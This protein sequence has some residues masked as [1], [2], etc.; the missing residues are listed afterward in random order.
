MV[1][2]ALSEISSHLVRKALLETIEE[3]LHSKNFK[4]K[5]TSASKAGE[6]NFIGIIHRVIFTK[7]DEDGNEN[8]PAANLILKVAPQNLLRRSQ[9]VVRPAFERE[10]YS[11]EKVSMCH[12]LIK[13][14]KKFLMK[15]H[16]VFL[17][18]LPAFRHFE[19]SKLDDFEQFGFTEYPKCYRTVE[20]NINEG[21]IFED[22]AVRGFTTIDRRTEEVTV[23][24]LR[25]VMQSL[26]KL[27]AISFAMKDQQIQKFKELAAN[28]SEVFI[29]PDDAHLREC[30]TKQAQLAF[31]AISGSDD[32]HLLAKVK[33][34]YE[35]DAIDVAA[36]CLDL[37]LTGSASVIGHS[38]CWQN[39][40]Q[41]KYDHNR[42][43]IEIIL[44][45][46]QTV[47]Q[48]KNFYCLLCIS[49]NF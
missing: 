27:H 38:D 24:H 33:K 12:G 26:G 40:V 31:D 47:R 41:F 35:K 36:E 44:L 19:Q 17:Q 48:G 42:K 23:D 15:C 1:E 7:L 16:F 8:G 39:N 21:L 20:L 32:A 29:R 14:F 22:L 43:P 13:K 5:V 10:I 2:S 45:D 25:L 28:L 49:L 4:I 18:I 11:Y 30:F 34:L 9:F 3:Q 46:W 6:N 37:R